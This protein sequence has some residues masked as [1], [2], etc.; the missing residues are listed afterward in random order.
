MQRFRFSP[1]S[2]QL[3]DS[4]SAVSRGFE[5]HAVWE[6]KQRRSRGDED[7]ISR[8]TTE[9]YES[10]Y[11]Q[12]SCVS[13]VTQSSSFLKGLR[14]TFKNNSGNFEILGNDGP[15]SSSPK[16]GRASPKP[17]Y[18]DSL[19][20]SGFVALQNQ[21]KTS[22][23]PPPDEKDEVIV[24]RT[25]AYP[26]GTER[27]GD[28]KALKNVRSNASRLANLTQS[29]GRLLILN[30][31]LT[32]RSLTSDD[33]LNELIRMCGDA[34]HGKLNY[35]MEDI[36]QSF[37]RLP[38]D[39]LH[40][41]AVLGEYLRSLHVENKM[42]D[43]L[44]HV[45]G[46][47]F[48]AHR[49]A[50]ACHSRYFADIF[51]KNTEKIKLPVEV[52]LPG[53]NPYAFQAFLRYIYTGQMIVSPEN[54]ADLMAVGNR[55][56]IQEILQICAE[57][58]QCITSDQA[59]FILANQSIPQDS[60]LFKH[61]YNLVLEN[62]CDVFDVEQFLNFTLDLVCMLLSDDYLYV[63]TE[64]DVFWAGLK[65]IAFHITER[66]THLIKVMKCVR[67][68]LMS[69]SELFQCMEVTDML[70]KSAS[71]REMVIAASWT[72][73][74]GEL[75]RPDPLLL[76]KPKPRMC[77]DDNYVPQ[78]HETFK[79]ILEDEPLYEFSQMPCIEET[80]PAKRPQSIQADNVSI[81]SQPS[82][83]PGDILAIGGF[84]KGVKEVQ[85][86]DIERYST[87]ENQWK[88]YTGLP[89]ARQHHAVTMLFGKLYLIGGSDPKKSKKTPIPTNTC[90]VFD[91]SSGEWAK[92][93]PLKT[94]RMYHCALSLFGILY[95]IGGQT[96]KNKVLS[97]V[98]CYNP[99]SDT[100]HTATDMSAPRCGFGACVADGRIF[101]AGGLGAPADKRSIMPVLRKF[102]CFDPKLNTWKALSSLDRGSCYCNL[103]CVGQY[104]YLCGGATK[105][106]NKDS[107]QS[108][109]SM[110]CYHIETDRWMYKTDFI[111]PRH[112][113]G[114]AVIGSKIYLIGG[115][116]TVDD[117]PL[118]S[119]ECFD[120]R[121]EC[122]DTSIQDLPYP[123]K[124]L[125]CVALPVSK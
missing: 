98:E 104:L 107:L 93:A 117:Q 59:V 94:P 102:E 115:V 50:L 56:Y 99:K 15:K 114:A 17:Y 88:Y 36:L 43:V 44:I 73:T 80:M 82:P 37:S 52:N 111:K 62:F 31:N 108:I 105:A 64:M 41:Y 48:A 65:W 38:V 35:T 60:V 97:S 12:Q 51:M 7:A 116:S 90:F 67:F 16:A 69:Q 39:K 75:G 20:D 70:R 54:V 118:Q 106:S 29:Q 14:E 6:R 123:A 25:M 92:T 103:V 9:L 79:S 61:A 4:E 110:M 120:A 76:H 74:A 121:T 85:A 55:F 87:T 53:V 77:M 45:S 10:E 19:G 83:R 30:D 63:H 22:Q 2:G 125:G 71:C 66:Q 1:V 42:V 112:N 124:W 100:W 23:K 96:D 3:G 86:K 32:L 119:I 89:E 49:V 28:N 46:Q 68:A 27:D 8:A 13:Q 24:N 47:T 21:G 58:V 84:H 101:V 34:Q 26:G 11:D 5:A 33:D 109:A 57:F 122:W 91:P 72:I 78:S 81:A 95:A 113:A 40:H 18:V